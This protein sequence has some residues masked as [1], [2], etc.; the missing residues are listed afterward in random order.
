MSYTCA[1][2]GVLARLTD[3]GGAVPKP[4][5]GMLKYVCQFPDFVLRAFLDSFPYVWKLGSMKAVDVYTDYLNWRWTSLE[6]D[7]ASNGQSGLAGFGE[8]AVA[9]GRLCVGVQEPLKAKKILE[10][11]LDLEDSQREILTRE[12]GKTGMREPYPWGAP[13]SDEGPCFLCYYGPALMV[14]HCESGIRPSAVET[15][16]EVYRAGRVLFPAQAGLIGCVTLEVAALKEASS[17]DLRG[18][19]S[20]GRVWVLVKSTEKQASVKCLQMAE[21]MDMARKGACFE[22]LELWS[23][24]DEAA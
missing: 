7:L 9:V 18:A 16:A 21:L 15:L 4:W 3:L 1:S 10:Q 2:I 24:Q 5:E 8:S 11:F 13:A 23:H 6:L 14:Q 22:V 20:K 12:M 19:G 17:A